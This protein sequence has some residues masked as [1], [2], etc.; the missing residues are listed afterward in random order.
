MLTLEE[1]LLLH[2][3]LPLLRCILPIHPPIL[4]HIRVSLTLPL[5]LA[6]RIVNIRIPK[7]IIRSRIVSHIYIT[8][9]SDGLGR[10]MVS[11]KIIGCRIRN[12]EYRMFQST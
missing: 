7:N 2:M 4:L 3:P 1:I 10:P 12:S 6:P 8:V 11:R 9:I 5:K